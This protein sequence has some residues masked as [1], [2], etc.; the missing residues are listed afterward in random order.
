M[1]FFSCSSLFYQPEYEIIKN[2]HL[3]SKI[4]HLK[5]KW[6]IQSRRSSFRIVNQKTS[7]T[8]ISNVYENNSYN[9]LDYQYF[10]L[11]FIII[12]LYL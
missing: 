7:G 4:N 6:L 5:I 11:I 1:R 3:Y 9:P 8:L 12:N 2:F 10:S